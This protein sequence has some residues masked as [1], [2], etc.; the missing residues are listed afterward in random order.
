MSSLQPLWLS[1]GRIL[2]GLSWFYAI[3]TDEGQ[4][5]ADVAPAVRA[6]AIA[7]KAVLT[8]VISAPDRLERVRWPGSG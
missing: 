1:R 4:R 8:S 7:D 3:H 5:A 2:E 6:R